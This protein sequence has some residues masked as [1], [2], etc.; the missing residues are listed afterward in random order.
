MAMGCSI[1]AVFTRYPPGLY[2][3]F[4]WLGPPGQQIY[5][6]QA[7]AGTICIQRICPSSLPREP[8]PPAPD[9]APSGAPFLACIC[10]PTCSDPS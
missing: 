6:Y 5:P 9:C 1:Q 2:T 7:C 8:A 4:T 10:P 3:V